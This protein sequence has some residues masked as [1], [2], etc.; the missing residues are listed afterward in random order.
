MAENTARRERQYRSTINRLK[1]ENEELLTALEK[2]VASN[3][4]LTQAL[5]QA[6]AEGE[7]VR[8][9]VREGATRAVWEDAA[10]KA[11]VLPELLDDLWKIDPPTIGEEAPDPKVIAAHL[12]KSLE[13]RPHVLKPPAEAEDDDDQA[14]DEATETEEDEWGDGEPVTTKETPTALDLAPPVKAAKPAAP[15][16]GRVGKPTKPA[17]SEAAP[18]LT[19]G[20]GAGKGERD[21]PNERSSVDEIVDRD[22]AATGR[23]NAFK[24]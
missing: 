4:E 6:Q 22:F 20:P 3:D 5:E 12:A 18:K 8:A 14:D 13:D 11:G 1:R 19:K 15:L 7:D 24:I 16:S 2:A 9:A 23:T 17:T 10:L 21:K